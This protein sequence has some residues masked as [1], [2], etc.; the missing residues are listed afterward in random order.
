MEAKILKL[1]L[2]PQEAKLAASRSDFGGTAANVAQRA[3]VPE[4]VTQRQLEEMAAK[5]LVS[6]HNDGGLDQFSLNDIYGIKMG[7]MKH[8]SDDDVLR[9]ARLWE[10]YVQQTGCLAE[11]LQGDHKVAR[12]VP[13]ASA[14][15]Q[16]GIRPMV[17]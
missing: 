11:L 12:V 2:T 1:V 5:G 8:P 10:D 13:A 7:G 6:H 4:P 3:V 9:F 14:V 17:I 15:K 16:D